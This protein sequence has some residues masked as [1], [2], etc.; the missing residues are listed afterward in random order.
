MIVVDTN[1]IAYLYID[2]E[3][4]EQVE[5]LLTLSSIWVSPI[6]WRSEFRNLLVHY[7]RRGSLSLEHSLM[8]LQEAESLLAG[9][10]FEVSSLKVMQ[11]ATSSRCSAYD[12]EFVALAQH[13]AVP[14]ITTDKQILAKF[15]D[16]AR[17]ACSY[18]A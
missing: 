4:T 10:E 14:L 12:C 18:L 17:S 5:R 15:P 2:G 6:L 11:L 7:V 1:I 16:T 3:H 13:L 8:I 9:H